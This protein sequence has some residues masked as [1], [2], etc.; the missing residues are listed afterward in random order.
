MQNYPYI[1]TVGAAADAARLSHPSSPF[2]KALAGLHE[3]SPSQSGHC[4]AEAANSEAAQ[5]TSAHSVH[6]AA[7]SSDLD[8]HASAVSRYGMGASLVC[9]EQGVPGNTAVPNG[10][11]TSL[12]TSAP[13]I[14]LARPP[15]DHIFLF[16]VGRDMNPEEVASKAVG[17]PAA[18]YPGGMMFLCVPWLCRKPT[19]DLLGC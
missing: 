18:S 19:T 5:P 17:R 4:S 3:Q 14:M 16:T 12:S 7:S 13:S 2:F 9:C 11:A 15:A 6:P 8:S 1:A 10:N